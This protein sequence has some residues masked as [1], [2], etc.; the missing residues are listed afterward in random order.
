MTRR[1]RLLA[2]FFSLAAALP[3]C[4]GDKA[5]GGPSPAAVDCRVSGACTVVAPA[6]DR[7]VAT[8]LVESAKFLYTGPDPLQ[9]DV[10]QTALDPKRLAV[11]RGK[12]G[13]AA[14]DPLAGVKISVI[15]HAE[16]GWTLTRKDGLFDMVVNGGGRVVFAY[17]KDSFVAAQR[18][19]EPQWQRYATIPDVGMI[20]L[21]S[22]ASKVNSGA[23][24][25]QI[26]VADQ[27]KDAH[28]SRQPLVLFASGTNASAEL[29]DG[30]TQPLSSLNVHVT[31]YPLDQ[32]KLPTRAQRF[33]PGSLPGS[34]NLSYTLEFTVDEA[35]ALGAT[36]VTFDQPATVYVENFLGLKSG[37]PVPIGYYNR[38]SSK[39]EAAD[40]GGVVV[41]I[42]S[43]TS[44][45]A[46]L[47]IDGDGKADG[48]DALTKIGVTDDE[49][50]EL[51]GRYQ[52]GQS[53]WR[54]QVSHFSAWDYL[55]P[56]APP[57]GA[58]GLGA[59]P[60][61]RPLDTPSVRGPVLVEK[62]VVAQNVGISGTPFSLHYQTDRTTRFKSGFEISVPLTAGKIPTGLKQIVSMVSVAGQEFDQTYDP[63]KNLTDVVDWDGTDSFGRLMQGRQ[64]AHV[65]VAYIFKGQ[66]SGSQVFGVPGLKFNDPDST[67]P[68]PDAVIWQDFDVQVGAFD[69]SG[70][71]LGGF[72]LDALHSYDPATQ[73]LYFG[74]GRDRTAQN[75]ALVVTRQ[76]KDGALGT[77][78]SV[79]A[80]PDGSVL[81][82]DDEQNDASAP[83]RILQVA[84]DGTVSVIA[85]AGATGA[86]GSLAIGSPQGIAMDTAGN[87]VF[88]DYLH[89]VVQS[90]APDGSVQTLIGLASDNPVAV[91]DVSDLDG[92]AFGQRGELYVVNAAQVLK[93]EGGQLSTF[94]GGGTADADE[95]PATQATLVVPS[96]V[97]V[98]PDGSVFV[99]ERGNP[100]ASDGEMPPPGGHRVR[101]ITPDGVI[102]TLAGT[103]SPGFSGDGLDATKALLSGPRGVTVGPDGSVYVA[104]QLNKRIRRITP[105]GIIMTVIGGGDATLADGQLAQEVLIDSP[106]GIAAGKDGTLF[107]AAPNTVYRAA[108]GLPQFDSKDSLIPSQ[109]G[110]TLY[111]FDARGKHQETLDAKTGVSLL[112]FHYD[113]NGLLDSIQ[114]NN[115]RKP[116]TIQR[117]SSGQL[118]SITAPFQQLTSVQLDSSDRITS[119]TDPLVDPNTM[120]GGRTVSFAYD[121]AGLG[122]LNSSTDPLQKTTSFSY[123]ALGRVK[124]LLGPSGYTEAFAPKPAFRG[125]SVDVTTGEGKLTN[126]SCASVADSLNCNITYPDG[127]KI[128]SG[129]R[130]VV[131]PR[132]AADGT[133]TTTVFGADDF[134]GA[135]ALNPSSV[136]VETPGGRVLD[137]TIVRSKH[138]TDASNALS[139]D[140]WSDAIDINGRGFF[141]RYTQKDRTE[142]STSAMQRTS[143]TT[144][145]AK[146]RPTDFSA[147]G[148]PATHWTYDKDGHVISVARTA[149]GTTR[150]DSFTFDPADGFMDSA[151]NNNAE[152][153]KYNRDIVGRLLD[154]N[155]PD[156]S[157]MHWDLDNDD[158]VTQF[159]PP[160]AS[161]PY[162]FAYEADTGL[163]NQSTPPAVSTGEKGKAGL[164]LGEKKYTYGS[165][166]ELQSVLR[167]DGSQV[168][169]QYD[170][171]NRVKQIALASAKISMGYDAHGTLTSVNRS[172][173]ARV[174]MTFDG[175][176]WLSS[177]WS[178]A[179]TGKV[180]ADYDK[181]FWLASLT[182]NDASTVNFTYDDDGL[183]IGASSAA[184]SLALTRAADTG[185]VT[186]TAL[187]S[188]T[189][190]QGYNGFG[191]LAALGANFQ[192][193]A[194]FSQVL[195]RDALGRIAHLSETVGT[196]ASEIDYTYDN[197]GRLTEVT[198]DGSVSDYA[199][200]A[201]GNRTSVT[202]DGVQ[203]VAATYDEQDRILTSG[204]ATYDKVE[205][206]DL[207][208]KTDGAN[209]L[210]L[211]YD[212][213]GNLMKASV[214]TGAKNTVVDYVIDGMGR[215]IARRVNNTF[216][217]AFLYR[218]GLRPVAEITSAG[219]FSHFVYAGGDSAPD[220]ILRAGVPF[221]V[222]KDH[223]G[224]VRLVVNATT[225]VVA[226]K[227]DYDEFGRVLG[228]SNPGFQPFGFAGGI[229]DSATGLV[230][231][232]ARDYDA[233]T[234][235]W[236]AKDPSGFAGGENQYAYCGD[237]PVNC[238]DPNGLDSTLPWY[239]RAAAIVAHTLEG[240]VEAGLGGG[241]ANAPGPDDVTVPAESE[242]TKIVV[243]ATLG[244]RPGAL[245][246]RALGE[247]TEFAIVEG[248]A[249]RILAA[250]RVGSGLKA[251]ALHRAASFVS[252]EQLTA[253]RVFALKGGD[254]VE[255]TLLQTRGAINGRG[256]IFEYILE[257]GDV[258]SHQRFIPG[259]RI[260]G[261]PNQVVR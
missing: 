226:Q 241:T 78:D 40:S 147:A 44:G 54:T 173:S 17:A 8:T 121:D 166:F 248:V 198:R 117:D 183:L 68:N 163:V 216:D 159:T 234:G 19:A 134:F 96:G 93:L 36:R 155:R 200:D 170:A 260:T 5:H 45:H 29:P 220:M 168:G 125:A 240:L 75:V 129:D 199:Y 230:R 128:Q 92:V 245:A 181:N 2:S 156:G 204:S 191:E 250:D 255:R 175:P 123:D 18:S 50:A 88:A 188:V 73:T 114:D 149:D 14:G 74:D 145:D 182:V 228:D 43:T 46:D 24:Q 59:P 213:L 186:D 56:I 139:L 235:R 197:L 225:G 119:V 83:G 76:S 157:L 85:G 205:T 94:A 237:D 105:D 26:A 1:A 233:E 37:S 51:G 201:S 60:Y 141:T 65:A 89:N 256:G 84:P 102:H 150:T 254:G 113:S 174:D 86:A 97:T 246:F 61:A 208:R 167:S 104:D 247:I 30:T 79:F 138:F 34:G 253:G 187:G 154:V 28:G 55:W 196:A 137:T 232:G 9:R 21:A 11:V 7:T 81:V 118:Q 176:L 223:L 62:Q 15:G 179:I 25:Q 158:R 10:D 126:Y 243:S 214:A 22:K 195:T 95:V 42:V 207:L 210:E 215:R 144:F 142:V 221:R 90:I 110:R 153:T 72:S 130:I 41:S 162:T 236:A 194:A 184:G 238:V 23:S 82:T 212:E 53:L 218:D 107:V 12:V 146:G 152:T 13:D 148:L 115:N 77:P 64:T 180:V 39:W 100:P 99:S 217:R 48:G 143:S 135:Q 122:L 140:D 178:G 185:F 239:E 227:L 20:A 52:V 211:T 202:V 192:N 259:G 49:L 71:E 257:P 35:E 193:Q 160:G 57:D 33:A 106:D 124:K 58:A 261:L 32:P 70:F 91:A 251:D 112:Q 127:S 31:E 209:S 169:I 165:D 222:I 120:K 103:G 108:P 203:T 131:Q 136:T 133:V 151:T 87:V 219:T 98:G 69:A 177:A 38:A 244:M 252:R 190:S 27:I 189:T 109:D 161:G 206:G 172:D 66:V 231:F 16:L 80:A 4:G 132:T 249:D 229:Y 224:S 242:A 164:S 47:D 111:R 258:V 67:G 116:T 101:K 171:S 63:A 6:L 3:S